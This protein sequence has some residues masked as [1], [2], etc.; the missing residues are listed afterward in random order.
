VEVE[1]A[2]WRACLQEAVPEGARRRRTHRELRTV[3]RLV[4]ATAAVWMLAWVV[5]REVR[6]P[7]LDVPRPVPAAT[8]AVGDLYHGLPVRVTA[9]PPVLPPEPRRIAVERLLSGAEPDAEPAP[10]AAP[11]PPERG[12]RAG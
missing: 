2:T 9:A 8:A 6:A 11:G 3:R 1:G 5:G 12:P 7:S 10:D 4:W